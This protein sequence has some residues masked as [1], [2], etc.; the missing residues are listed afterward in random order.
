[1]PSGR[2]ITLA[3]VNFNVKSNLYLEPEP[4]IP[5]LNPVIAY[6]IGAI[7]MIPFILLPMLIAGKLGFEKDKIP[8]IVYF[9]TGAVGIVVVTGMGLWQFWAS[10]F[11]LAMGVIILIAM[12]LIGKSS[13]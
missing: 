3:S 5:I 10:F 6:P 13:K 8:H 1:M 2:Q 7:V 4:L 9:L 11:V 12:F